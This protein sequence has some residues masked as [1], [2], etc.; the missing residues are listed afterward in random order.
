MK[1]LLIGHGHLGLAIT[2]EFRAATLLSGDNGT[3][4]NAI[5]GLTVLRN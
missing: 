3:I 2:R 5:P 4:P 1:L